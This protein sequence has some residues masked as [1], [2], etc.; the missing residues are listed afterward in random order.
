MLFLVVSLFFFFVFFSPVGGVAFNVGH[1]YCNNTNWCVCEA[2]AIA[3]DASAVVAGV[4]S[5][6]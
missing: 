2:L 6:P 5:P 3:F 1:C 4:V